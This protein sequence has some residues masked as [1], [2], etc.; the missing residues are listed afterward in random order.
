MSFLTY[1]W[2]Q[3]EVTKPKMCDSVCIYRLA[4]GVVTLTC[5]Q[6]IVTNVW[7]CVYLTYIYFLKTPNGIAF[8]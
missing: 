3:M 2:S 7:F 1:I 6:A 8:A 5:T 4:L